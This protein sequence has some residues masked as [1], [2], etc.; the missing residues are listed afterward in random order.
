MNIADFIPGQRY[1]T[2]HYRPTSFEFVKSDRMNAYF[3]N[4]VIHKHRDGRTLPY[5][6]IDGLY[7]FA[8][9]YIEAFFEPVE[10]EKQNPVV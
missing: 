10:I 9:D 7:P 8:L 6:V 2:S 1:Y 3:K 5:M 4:P